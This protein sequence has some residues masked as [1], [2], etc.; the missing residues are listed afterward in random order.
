MVRKE[1]THLRIYQLQ[2]VVFLR[3]ILQNTMLR[4][5][6]AGTSG[7]NFNYSGLIEIIGNCVLTQLEWCNGYINIPSEVTSIADLVF[8]KKP[9]I[10]VLE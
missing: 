2:Q 7:I 8:F 1:L 3:P 6:Y 4:G 10:Q 5:I 9:V